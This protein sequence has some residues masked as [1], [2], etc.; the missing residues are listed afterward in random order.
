MISLLFAFHSSQEMTVDEIRTHLQIHYNLTLNFHQAP[1]TSTIILN[2]IFFDLMTQG[3]ID[4]RFNLGQY[5]LTVHQCYF[6]TCAIQ[7]ENGGAIFFYRMAVLCY[8]VCR[9][10][11]SSDK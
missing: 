4:F 7:N 6:G 5:N 9:N 2:S 11:L 3:A 10:R 1:Q 8:S